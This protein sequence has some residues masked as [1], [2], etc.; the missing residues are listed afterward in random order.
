MPEAIETFFLV[1]LLVVVVF[2]CAVFFFKRACRKRGM[3]IF[4]NPIL[5]ANIGGG[6]SLSVGVFKSHRNANFCSLFGISMFGTSKNALS[7]EVAGAFI[8]ENK[9]T[10]I[11]DISGHN[12]DG[13]FVLVRNK[14]R[15][16]VLRVIPNGTYLEKQK[17]SPLSPRMWSE[18]SFIL[19]I[20]S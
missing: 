3:Q 6:K 20:L 12:S 8:D 11:R 18:G 9:E 14:D 4:K 10:I 17:I 7:E 13:F 1:I 2:F 5:T 19:R 16:S 15:L